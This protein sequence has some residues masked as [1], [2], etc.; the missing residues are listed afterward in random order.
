MAQ[1]RGPP[2]DPLVAIVGATG[3]GKSQ[4]AVDLAK[5]FN[6]EIINGD[7]MQMYAGL[8]II[9][10]KIPESEREGVPHHLLGCVGLAEETWRVGIFIE[11]ALGVIKEIR[12]RGRVPILV[13]G[14][15]Y[16]TQALLFQ[17]TLAHA[18]A[19]DGESGNV[20][21]I[22][23]KEEVSSKY[24]ILDGSTEEILSRLREVDPIMA[25]RWHPN[26]HRKIRRSLEI[27]LMTG[28]RASDIYQKQHER[29]SGTEMEDGDGPS[30][31][32]AGAD[33][34]S[35]KE[36]LGRFPV[37]LLWTHTA[38]ERLQARLNSRVD[39][40][41]RNGML[42]EV[43]E[44]DAFLDE[45][46]SRGVT[47]D[48][49]RGVW[50]SIGFKEFEA[51]TSALKTDNVSEEEAEMFKAEAIEKT[52]I[53]TRQYAKGQVRRI[54][55]K[56]LHAL[57]AAELE[58]NLFLLDASEPGDW[59]TDVQKPAGDLV[60]QFLAG[61]ELPAA[62]SLSQAAEEMLV[63]LKDYD[64]SQRRELWTR[65]TCETC[66]VTSVVPQDWARHLRSRGHRRRVQKAMKRQQR[67]ESG[68]A[69]NENG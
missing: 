51:Y 63:P 54:R 22:L 24:P 14:T 8:P 67:A 40:M 69:E 65:E 12:S 34:A 7:A 53:A 5:R 26:D 39:D 52:K 15:H 11:K 4:L 13:G 2:R 55:I 68:H 6:G 3:T 19:G 33:E 48:K 46:S 56:L 58:Q 25:D 31:T 60:K 35:V 18:E 30:D 59:V 17:D 16:Y 43:W 27:Y 36:H 44:M 32:G 42:S 23:T 61:E 28:Q 37:L 41:V 29:R 9:T 50:V 66:G 49:T 62:T 47:V 38:P 64:L 21:G 20:G 1:P 57:K 10:N 45:G